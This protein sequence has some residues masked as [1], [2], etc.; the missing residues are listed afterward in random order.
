MLDSRNSQNSFNEENGGNFMKK[1]IL[2][3]LMI[4]MISLF[5]L[6]GVALAYSNGSVTNNDV[7]AYFID[8]YMSTD[9]AYFQ[10]VSGFQFQYGYW[11]TYQT[12]QIIFT[13]VATDP[14]AVITDYISDIDVVKHHLYVNNSYYDKTNSDMTATSFSG[15]SAYLERN[16][17]QEQPYPYGI[18]INTTSN[19]K[20]GADF[21]VTGVAGV[22][23]T[24]IATSSLTF[25]FN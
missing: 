21:E 23:F 12:S 3:K 11:L 1:S 25:S 4:C 24:G 9:T 19:N 17:T 7:G 18:Q 5:I 8:I 13:G 22:T 10:V 14:F 2:T 6:S 15:I 16:I 20:I